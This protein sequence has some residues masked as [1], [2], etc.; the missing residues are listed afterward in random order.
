MIH[1]ILLRSSAILMLVHAL[2]HT[3]GH[4]NWKNPTDPVLRG[5]VGEMISH[6]IPFM[7]VVQSYGQYFEGYGYACSVALLLMGIIFWIVSAPARQN[8]ALVKRIVFVTSCALL[9]WAVVEQIYFFPLAAIIT[10]LAAA[11]G[12]VSYLLRVSQRQKQ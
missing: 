7:G 1:K 11:G 4:M 2:M 9:A 12:F 10:F 8:D 5:V 3:M 6:P